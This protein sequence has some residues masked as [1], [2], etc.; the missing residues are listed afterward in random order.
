MSIKIFAVI[1]K[2]HINKNI[3]ASYHQINITGKKCHFN[4]QTINVLNFSSCNSSNG[5]TTYI[6][7]TVNFGYR[8]S[9]HVTACR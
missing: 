3:Q 7:K 8:I 4:H 2:H 9:N 1:Y 5:N 6:G